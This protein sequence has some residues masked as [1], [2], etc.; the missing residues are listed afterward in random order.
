MD[1]RVKVDET[2]T[3][4]EEKVEVDISKQIEVCTGKGFICLSV[5]L[6]TILLPYL[7]IFFTDTQ[8]TL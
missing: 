3:E 8:L 2:G 7:V 6:C 5:Y 1:Y 4:F